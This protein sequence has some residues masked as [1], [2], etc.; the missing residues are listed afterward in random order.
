MPVHKDTRWESKTAIV[1]LTKGERGWG[2]TRRGGVVGESHLGGWVDERGLDRDNTV[3]LSRLPSPVS[4]LTKGSWAGRRTDL[5]EQQ[6]QIKQRVC[7]VF[8]GDGVSHHA[9]DEIADRGVVC[10][11]VDGEIE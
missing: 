9:A 2:R 3:A 7:E 6:F 8:F 4:P 10:G 5:T 1:K 11:F